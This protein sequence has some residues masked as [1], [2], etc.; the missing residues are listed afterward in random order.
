MIYKVSVIVPIYNVE[1]FIEKCV[2]NLLEQTLSEVE[3]IFVDDC[4]PDKSIEILES[5][6]QQYPSRIP[7]VKI[8]RHEI[9]KGLPA[10]RN[11]GLKA[12]TG[13]YVFHCDSDDWLE[14]YSLELLY[15][16]AISDDADIV[17]CDWFLSFK[18]NERYM[19]QNAA[20]DFP[21]TNFEALKL[22][23]GGQIKYNVWNKLVKLDL[24]KSNNIF[25]P[26]GYN[27]GEDMTMIK[28]FVHALRVTYLTEALYHYMQINTNAY[29]KK[30]QP[31]HLGQILYNVD[32]VVEYIQ[33]FFAN[34][35]DVY[36]HF[37]KLNV[38]LPFL[39]SLDSMSYERWNEWYKDSNK[40]IDQNPMF[41]I[42]T[43]W[44]Q[45]AAI[46]RQYWFLKLYNTLLIRV[47]YGI[48][49]K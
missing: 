37:F 2:I 7:H 10:A 22:L 34:K 19:S 35:L 36:I 44:I 42:R 31:S 49:Y 32:N 14:K 43:R 39:I 27:M 28:L 24:Y 15:N 48:V 47:I 11:S 41:N 23:L 33:N 6:I 1:K 13:E 4:T 29:T 26:E 9:N 3:L 40:Y 20:L 8:I 46:K 25:F 12:A 5:L 45:K 17:W 18:D 30:I 21:I 16:K 38:K